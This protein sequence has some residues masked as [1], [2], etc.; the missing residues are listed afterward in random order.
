MILQRMSIAIAFYY[1]IQLIIMIK[2]P[3]GSFRTLEG[4]LVTG[5]ICSICK[6]PASDFWTGL[7]IVPREGYGYCSA[8]CGLI[9]TFKVNLSL[10]VVLTI[11]S[12][13]DAIFN[14]HAES[15]FEFPPIF[16]ALP[17]YIFTGIGFY[18]MRKQNLEKREGVGEDFA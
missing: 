13:L 18:F 1:S 5:R 2:K 8:K 14:F 10:A 11:I 9:G 7:T 15:L 3:R 16:C 6:K 17:F 4:G 12:I